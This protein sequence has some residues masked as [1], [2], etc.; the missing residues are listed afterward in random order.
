MNPASQSTPDDSGKKA[1]SGGAP[2]QIDALKDACRR[3]QRLLTLSEAKLTYFEN[4]PEELE[5]LP[6]WEFGSL[7]ST[8]LRLQKDL[9]RYVDAIEAGGNQPKPAK[10]TTMPTLQDLL[11]PDILKAAQAHG[12]AYSAKANGGKPGHPF[13]S[14]N[15]R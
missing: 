6:I 3:T 15:K 8:V 1:F 2:N 10:Q 12:S 4:N 5:A 13:L 11:G 14:N 7:V 9:L